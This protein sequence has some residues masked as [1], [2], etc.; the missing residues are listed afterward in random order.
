M[1]ISRVLLWKNMGIKP[2]PP[3]KVPKNTKK[4]KWNENEMKIKMKTQIKMKKKPQSKTYKKG[5]Q[6]GKKIQ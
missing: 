5:N 3:K 6:I 1:Q 4:S 2:Q